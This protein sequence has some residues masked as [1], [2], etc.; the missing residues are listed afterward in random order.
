MKR[1]EEEQLI[2]QCLT[3]IDQQQ[4]TLGECSGELNPW[5]YLDQDRFDQEMQCL[6][7][8][9]PM[10]CVHVSE[11]PKVGSSKTLKTAMG[12]LIVIRSKEQTV[13]VF[14]NICLHRGA[15]LLPVGSDC[16]N[17]LTCPYHGWV[18]ELN[19][20]LKGVPSQASCFPDLNLQDKQLHQ[21]YAVE[22]FGLI[23]IC[24]SATDQSDAEQ[25]LSRHL[26]HVDDMFHWMSLE[27]L[28]VFKSK[29]KR[30]RCNWKILAEGG[31]ET[32]H[33]AK[34][35]QKTIAPFFTNNTSLHHSLGLHQ[36]VIIPSK[37]Y[38]SV[39]KQN[40]FK[41]KLRAFTHTLLALMPQSSF[42]IQEHHVDWIQ[43][44]P[45]SVDETEL[46]I[47]SLIPEDP[48]QLSDERRRHWQTN[49]SIT[50]T[51]LD[52]D[53]EIGEGIQASMRAHPSMAINPGLSETALLN[54]NHTVDD[55]CEHSL[56]NSLTQLKDDVA[57]VDHKERIT[58][59]SPE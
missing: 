7:Q 33:F 14:K 54:F 51:T 42:L 22:R 40:P 34:A 5:R 1:S 46:T 11:L 55:L 10:P 19:G 31:L 2:A 35:H 23:W 56:T 30:W 8:R 18:Y 52:E 15:R 48:S 41:Q 53:F 21:V 39:K 32:Y 26:S 45:I 16:Q 49:F 27:T 36:R 43:A 9:L 3:L 44:R 50:L 47:V 13:R 37:A 29:V 59:D 38:L 12:E 24:P 17:K 20:Q 57:N 6:Y 58:C 28:H 4:T 25:Q